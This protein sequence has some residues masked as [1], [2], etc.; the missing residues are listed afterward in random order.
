MISVIVSIFNEEKILSNNAVGFKMLSQKAELIF[1]N[2]GSAD[3]SAR[4]TERMAAVRNSGV[5]WL[6][7]WPGHVRR[8]SDE[9]GARARNDP[10]RNS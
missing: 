3:R 5:S 6:G 2:G 10:R 1:V 9:G 8:A 4:N 7:R